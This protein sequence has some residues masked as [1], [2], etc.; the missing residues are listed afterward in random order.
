VVY[1]GCFRGDD[2]DGMQG[3]GSHGE[4]PSLHS[5]WILGVDLG[6][7]RDLQTHFIIIKSLLLILCDVF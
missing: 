1:V 7:H 5:V 2:V 6:S 4:C 3:E